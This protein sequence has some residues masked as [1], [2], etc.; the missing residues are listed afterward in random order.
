MTGFIFGGNSLFDLIETVT[1]FTGR[2]RPLPR[3]A[4]EGAI[5]GLELGEE[6]VRNITNFLYD[7]NVP[8][9][10]VWMQDWAGMKQFPEG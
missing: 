1:E 4:S 3:W 8:I 5:I 10:G 7:N 2:M 6:F 9:V